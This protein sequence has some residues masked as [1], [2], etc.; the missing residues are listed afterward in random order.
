VQLHTLRALARGVTVASMA[1]A[2]EL[3]MKPRDGPAAEMKETTMNEQSTNDTKGRK[4][5]HTIYLVTGEGEKANWTK[6]A[7]AWAHKDGKGFGGECAL[8]RIVI[9]P[10]T[11]REQTTGGRQ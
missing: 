1:V 4:P 3:P 2:Q 8:G 7:A 10:V 11:Q 9:R 5:T 6:L